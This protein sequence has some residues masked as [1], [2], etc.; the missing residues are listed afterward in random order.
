M[1]TSKYNV[2]GKKIF[3]SF[4]NKNI[5]QKKLL[6]VFECSNFTKENV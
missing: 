1:K 4:F 3:C 5:E 6:L 2:F